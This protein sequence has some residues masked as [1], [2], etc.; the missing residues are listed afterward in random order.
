MMKL[1]FT[2]YF[3]VIYELYLYFIIIITKV[4]NLLNEYL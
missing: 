4:S 2:N 1:R 3:V